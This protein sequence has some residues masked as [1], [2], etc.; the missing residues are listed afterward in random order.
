MNV[1]DLMRQAVT[2]NRRRTAV[3]H[4]AR[5]ITFGEAWDRATRFANGLLALGLQPGDRVGVLEDNS[6]EI[7]RYHRRL[8]DRQSGP[9]AALRPQRGRYPCA[10]A[11]QYPVSRTGGERPLCSRSGGAGRC[12]RA[13]AG[14]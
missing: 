12:G 6:F 3:V 2:T 13:C 7:G 5:R 8:R 10:H 4:D 11:G 14:P 1:R 9:R